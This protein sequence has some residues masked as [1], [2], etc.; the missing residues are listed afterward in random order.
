MATVAG[1]AA[2]VLGGLGGAVCE[3]LAERFPVPLRRLGLDDVFGQSGGADELMTH[4]GLTAE[5]AADLARAVI[6]AKTSG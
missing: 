3:V 4:Y 5:R 6:S 2:A 1:R